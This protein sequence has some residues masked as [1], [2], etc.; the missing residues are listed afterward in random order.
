M[1]SQKWISRLA[2]PAL[3]AGMLL[4]LYGQNRVSDNDLERFIKNLHEDAK[5]FRPVFENG[6]KK[7]S[8]RKTSQ[9]KDAK[10]TAERFEKQTDSF[11][12]NFKRTHKGDADLQL[13][14]TTAQQIDAVV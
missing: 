10:I 1:T 3:L 12:E 4:P 2:M 8:I 7:S 13:V 5:A 11:A 6:L 9:E 14:V